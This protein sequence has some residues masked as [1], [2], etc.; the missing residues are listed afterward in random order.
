M[1]KIGGLLSRRASSRSLV[2]LAA[3]AL[4]A[5]AG[6][7]SFGPLPV[8][9]PSGIVPQLGAAETLGGSITLDVASVPV[10]GPTLFSLTDVSVL[11]SGGASF[12]LDP[13]VLSPALGVVQADGGFLIPTLFLRV[14][15][16]ATQL[17]LAVPNVAGTL[18]FGADGSVVGLASSFEVDSLSPAGILA[19]NV[20]AG[21][22]EPASGL[23]LLL[24]LGAIAVKEKL[25]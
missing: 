4:A 17:D 1:R 21:A 9:P 16:G 14:T 20:V 3:L 12:A 22:P 15:D 10:A 23:L 19:V 5:P 18:F 11:A 2:V 24:G 8:V 6:A 25:R 13:T 7:V